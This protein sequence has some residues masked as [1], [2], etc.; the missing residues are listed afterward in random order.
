MG[1]LAEGRLGT[2]RRD[3]RRPC[4]GGPFGDSWVGPPGQGL[5]SWSGPRFPWLQMRSRTT[6]RVTLEDVAVDFTW[7]EWQLLGEPQRLLYQDVMLDNFT[8]V[9]SLG[10]ASSQIR[11]V[12]RLEAGE[13]TWAPGRAG[14]GPAASLGTWRGPGPGC[15][16]RME[17]AEAPLQAV[18]RIR[19][20]GSGSAAH[21]AEPCGMC[22]PVVK[23]VLLLAEH[24]GICSGQKL[25]ACRACGR[26]F[27]FSLSIAQHQDGE[28]LPSGEEDGASPLTGCR[29]H[30]SEEP[31]LCGDDGEDLLPH[32]GPLHNQTADLQ[33]RPPRSAGCSEVVPTGDGR[34]QCRECGK[35]F[36]Q[37][38]RLGQHQRVHAGGKPHVCRECGKAFRRKCRLVQHQKIHA[39]D[40]SYECTQCGKSF[41]QSYGLV[42]HQRVHTGAKPYNCVECGNFFGC[43]TT[44]V[45]HQ[46][47]HTGERPYKCTECGKS[48]RQ[49]SGLIGHQ[50]IH[51][52]AKPYECSECG[53]FFSRKITLVRHRRIH[54][55]ERPYKCT[56]CGKFFSQS[57]GLVSHQRVHTGEKPYECTECGKWFS[58][59]SSL[60]LHQRVHTGERPYACS[61]CGKAFSL[62]FTLL[63]HQRTHAEERPYERSER[64]K[65]F[66]H[67]S[68][69]IQHRQNHVGEC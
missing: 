14:V 10:F 13:G 22:G 16:F 11:V 20:P 3:F 1:A 2:S 18:P 59:R 24:Q 49:R 67:K 42:Q 68:S 69:L 5:S 56:E 52:G 21:S 63:R 36:S 61:E 40:R 62:K 54:T 55:G 30:L 28:G 64:R 29:G 26:Q 25:Q 41:R 7:E 66:S 9:A 38:H 53:K 37:Q 50:R 57:S 39:R 60:N 32:P 6:H 34:Y 47:I 4:G 8:L 33:G 17:N 51:T 65:C 44:L 48:F 23:D 58:H 45:R 15:W 35:A 31:F 46:R 27:C 43:K 19:T 12:V